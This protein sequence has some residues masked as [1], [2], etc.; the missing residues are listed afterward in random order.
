[1]VACKQHY[2]LMYNMW[3]PV[4]RLAS[5][6]LSGYGT[7]QP[8]CQTASEEVWNPYSLNCERVR[9]AAVCYK[10]TSGGQLGCTSW[11][12]MPAWLV[13]TGSICALWRTTG[14]NMVSGFRGTAVTKYVLVFLRAQ[15]ASEFLILAICFFASYVDFLTACLV[16]ILMCPTSSS[17]SPSLIE[18]PVRYPCIYTPWIVR[19]SLLWADYSKSI[20]G[21]N[22]ERKVS[23]YPDYF[24]NTC[25]WL[26][27]IILYATSMAHAS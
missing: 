11:K 26:A 13:I 6:V 7:K 10:N 25:L 27:Y 8:L 9:T 14:T 19:C 12:K 5:L 15:L 17:T 20:T 16:I 18:C 22:Q 3:C 1:M 2:L 23:F 24:R 21:K 4:A